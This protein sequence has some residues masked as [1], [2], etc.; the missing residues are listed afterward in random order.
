MLSDQSCP[1]VNPKN[2]IFWKHAGTYTSKA[3]H[4]KS[5]AGEMAYMIVTLYR[6]G[7]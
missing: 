5:F 4:D 3:S 2:D 6:T 7:T 1:E